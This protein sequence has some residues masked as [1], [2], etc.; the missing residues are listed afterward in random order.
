MSWRRTNYREMDVYSVPSLER[1]RE[2]LS[3][4]V[5]Q[6]KLPYSMRESHSQSPLNVWEGEAGMMEHMTLHFPLPSKP[7]NVDLR[8]SESVACSRSGS[9]IHADLPAKQTLDTD[10]ARGRKRKSTYDDQILLD[11]FEPLH[12]RISA[13][14][15]VNVQP[16]NLTS[17]NTSNFT[18]DVDVIV[19]DDDDDENDDYHDDGF[20]KNIKAAQE[21][22]PPE[23]VH[24]STSMNTHNKAVDKSLKTG[25][26]NQITNTTVDNPCYLSV[27]EKSCMD[28]NSIDKTD[29]E[30]V[31]SMSSRLLYDQTMP[32]R[33][34]LTFSREEQTQLH[35]EVPSALS[36]MEIKIDFDTG[37]ASLKPEPANSAT[38]D[39][40][41]KDCTTS[42]V[43]D[44]T[45]SPENGPA[46]DLVKQQVAEAETT[47]ALK[48]KLDEWSGSIQYIQSIFNELQMSLISGVEDYPEKFYQSW[49]QV[50]FLVECIHTDMEVERM[51][52]CPENTQIKF[53]LS[54]NLIKQIGNFTAQKTCKKLEQMKTTLNSMRKALEALYVGNKTIFHE[55]NKKI[56]NDELKIKNPRLYSLN[57]HN[58]YL[59]YRRGKPLS[60]HL[61]PGIS[62]GL[63][64]KEERML[65][66]YAN[67]LLQV[68]ALSR[69]RI[70]APSTK[71]SD[72]HNR[73]S[74]EAVRKPK[75]FSTGFT[76]NSGSRPLCSY[77]ADQKYN[78]DTE[79]F[80]PQD[81]S[82]TRSS[83]AMF[84]GTGTT[85][86]AGD[87]FQ[88][89]QVSSPYTGAAQLFD[90]KFEE[91]ESTVKYIVNVVS[92]TRS[93]IYNSLKSVKPTI[94]AEKQSKMNPMKRDLLHEKFRTLAG[95]CYIT[96]HLYFQIELERMVMV[97]SSKSQGWLF[98]ADLEFTLG[99]SASCSFT[100]RHKTLKKHLANSALII[101]KLFKDTDLKDSI[102]LFNK[103]VA[104][105]GLKFKVLNL[106]HL[107]KSDRFA[108]LLSASGLKHMPTSQG[109]DQAFFS[110]EEKILQLP[111]KLTMLPIDFFFCKVI[112]FSETSQS[113]SGQDGLELCTEFQNLCRKWESLASEIKKKFEELDASLRALEKISPANNE[114]DMASTNTE[115]AHMSS[116]STTPSTN[117]ETACQS[118][119]QA[120][121]SLQSLSTLFVCLAFSLTNT[122]CHFTNT[123]K[124]SK[125]V[126]KMVRLSGTSKDKEICEQFKTLY[127]TLRELEK[128]CYQVFSRNI[129]VLV[130]YNKQVDRNRQVQLPRLI[131][132]LAIQIK[133]L[134]HKESILKTTSK[135]IGWFNEKTVNINAPAAT[136]V[137]PS[138]AS[139]SLIA[140]R[141]DC[142]QPGAFENESTLALDVQEK[143]G[144][145][146][147]KPMSPKSCMLPPASSRVQK[148]SCVGRDGA[149]LSGDSQRRDIPRVSVSG[150]KEYEEPVVVSRVTRQSTKKAQ[151]LQGNREARMEAHACTMESEHSLKSP[152]TSNL[153]T[154]NIHSFV[155]A[156]DAELELGFKLK[157]CQDLMTT[158]LKGLET[159]A[160]V[161]AETV[162]LRDKQ[163]CEHGCSGVPLLDT[164]N[165]ALIRAGGD[166]PL[167]LRLYLLRIDIENLKECLV[168]TKDE[169]G[170]TVLPQPTHCKLIIDISA[171]L[172][173]LQSL[174]NSD[175][176]DAYRYGC[177]DLSLV[178]ED[179]LKS[180]GLSK[181][182]VITVDFQVVEL[183]LE[184]LVDDLIRVMIEK[185]EIIQVFF[186]HA[187]GIRKERYESN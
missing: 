157:N 38:C 169:M 121:L 130:A 57:K 41:G 139:E 112:K 118:L 146:T 25:E 162:R 1:A 177:E 93:E 28:S 179:A 181:Q 62:A 33:V 158:C 21:A 72:N 94:S 84:D 132:N 97:P 15:S 148:V 126:T 100:K 152:T 174:L 68:N 49:R 129:D 125:N 99:K 2:D 170:S 147:D 165:S 154:K 171:S 156:P 143:L 182:D 7:G 71:T 75:L 61:T 131:S 53:I 168:K 127:N 51:A 167:G 44:L 119:I 29:K 85:E 11:Y 145:S 138:L 133:I 50:C 108:K 54:K 120:G 141:K 164:L 96:E 35:S 69:T 90:A 64:G 183:L 78:S 166:K 55:Y 87:D 63:Y 60:L 18:Q 115:N 45:N 187:E 42:N 56:K 26:H 137:V 175:S 22:E 70:T 59:Y 123:W 37:H 142:I 91:W 155:L 9:S 13:T 39:V 16:E 107:E 14:P 77:S 31:S 43:L 128:N 111:L 144:V 110:S 20:V 134:L 150:S 4:L 117:T 52:L 46:K 151:E 109:F 102:K 8:H 172:S 88:T 149:L 163:C 76:D 184:F 98:S 86:V 104:K 116:M 36:C 30:S 74:E 23:P 140:N 27:D 32:H 10:E 113:R 81:H 180:I 19:I 114:A 73:L 83:Q 58:R 92:L 66:R 176:Y 24:P 101:L 79:I 136:N 160:K 95:L 5:S 12:H 47:F 159:S 17:K 186:P 89:H 173:Y 65:A 40:K 34:S 106:I 185:R 161:E 103:K 124:L 48:T 105:G 3:W 82:S 80:T 178:N 135:S 153:N 67:W 122:T 6:L